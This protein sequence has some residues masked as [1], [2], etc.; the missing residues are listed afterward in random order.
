MQP[1]VDSMD[2]RLVAIIYTYI[3]SF[4]NL[5][6]IG[7]ILGCIKGI[8]TPNKFNYISK[9]VPRLF[10]SSLLVSLLSDAIV[11]LFTFFI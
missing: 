2:P 10:L 6:I 8:T 11:S 4:A 1:V 5:A 7:I 9:N 3:A